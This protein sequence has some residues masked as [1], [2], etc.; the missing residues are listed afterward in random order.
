MP[1]LRRA[2][3]PSPSPVHAWRAPHEVRAQPDDAGPADLRAAI[4]QARAA[5]HPV[6]RLVPAW[7]ELFQ[8]LPRLGELL[9]RTRSGGAVHETIGTYPEPEIAADHIAI[10]KRP[11][12]L[13]VSPSTWAHGLVV[14]DG[15]RP[16]LQ[17]YD[18]H[19]DLVHAIH[20]R[21]RTHL[22][23]LRALV[24]TLRAPDPSLDL[25]LSP[26]PARDPDRPD[27]AIDRNSLQIGW[28]ALDDLH[29]F[30]D[31]LRAHGVSPTQA[32]RLAP[33]GHARRVPASAALQVLRAAAGCVLP[34]TIAVERPGCLHRYSGPIGRVLVQEPW[35]G[36]VDRN[37]S[38]RLRQDRIA[39]A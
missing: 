6:T 32:L 33:D 35:V 11:L 39:Q 4:E 20:A 26:R 16:R 22:D 18:A 12:D 19:G 37:V 36:V 21:P 28:F 17:F 34:I 24:D 23:E 13:R 25:D 10:R 1:Q 38:F 2:P 3:P 5:G 27:W 14:A 9:A 30:A 7:S 15:E 8:R 29:A 31:L